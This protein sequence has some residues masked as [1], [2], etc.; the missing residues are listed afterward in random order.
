MWQTWFSKSNGGLGRVVRVD[1]PSGCTAIV[2]L[3]TPATVA[4]RA[5]TLNITSY[6]RRNIPI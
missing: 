6:C 3:I 2:A 5:D 4:V 1:D